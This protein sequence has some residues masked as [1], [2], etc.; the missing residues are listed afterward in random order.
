M[1]NYEVVVGID[2]GS[3]GTGFAYSFFNE[4][5]ILTGEIYGASANN[6]I[7]TEI[8]LDNNNYTVQFGSE[9]EKFLKEKGI[10]AGHYFKGI[11][12]HLYENKNTIIASN[13]GKEISLKIV[14]QRVLEKIKEI[15]IKQISQNRPSLAKEQDKI[16][17]IVTVPAI[18]DERQKGIMMESCE[19]A[20]LIN[21]NTD[22]S[23]FFA[24]E[25]EA[26]SLYCSRNKEIEQKYFQNGEYYIVCDLGGGTGDIVAHLV[27]SNHKLAEISPSCG[28]NFGSNEIDKLIFKEIIQQLFGCPDFNTYYYKL[29]KNNANDTKF[30]DDKGQY[31]S[32]W[33]EFERKI[34]EF[35]EDAKPDHI[36]NNE[37]STIDC[38]IFK[39]I[40]ADNIELD[41]LVKEYND[42]ISYDN[43]KLSVRKNK[44]KWLVEFPYN[45]IYYYMERQAQSICKIINDISANEKIHTL[46]FVGGYCSNDIITNLIET[47]LKNIST[48][49]RPSNPNLAV[50]EG[51][52][53]FGIKPSNII[54]RK[55]K[56]TIGSNINE[57]CDN[58]KINMD[59]NYK[60]YDEDKKKWFYKDCFDKYI[61]VDQEIKFGE[62]ISHEISMTDKRY[63]ELYFFKTKKKNPKY[64]NEEGVIQI[65]KFVLDIGKDY[66]KSD[67]R[68]V[69]VTMKFGGTFIDVTAIHLK[70]GITAKSSYN[71]D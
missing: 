19:A 64:I 35:K 9:C 37:K 17:W 44:Y 43:L 25:P 20:G 27:G 28:G 22:K 54:I 11:K 16:K 53:L 14:I 4:N 65:G 59:D 24:L 18:W 21:Q 69:K 36:K 46:I 31:Y 1:S 71:F 39:E 42:N 41:E 6:K 8:I 38:S 66:E 62:L 29:K 7:P 63:L 50:M 70:T 26:A 56:Y 32:D 12:M 67:E 23:L 3:S 51:A 45:I 34:K 68:K 15:A 10:D 33:M 40:F 60:Y 55:A 5:K 61:E 30:I 58:N 47:G 52:V 48:I 57:I 13:S 49:L 2:F